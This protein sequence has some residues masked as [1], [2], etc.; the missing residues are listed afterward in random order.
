LGTHYLSIRLKSG[1]HLQ[2]ALTKVSAV[3]K[4]NNPEYPVDLQ[5]INDDLNQLFNTETLT[6]KLA[7]IFATLAI[8]I[9]CLGLFGLA[10]YTA[11]RRIKEI[12]IRKILGASVSGLVGLLSKNFLQ[13]VGYSCLI[14]FPLSWW[15]LHNWL[16]SYAYRTPIHWWVFAIAGVLAMLIALATVCFQ[17]IKAAMTNPVKNLRTE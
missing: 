9:S 2:E 14:S 8:F 4:A 5:S 12:G 15:A 7:G 6:A 10:A 17:A 1:A 16:Q 3:L 13:L 11:E